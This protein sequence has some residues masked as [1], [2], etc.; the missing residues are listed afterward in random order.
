MWGVKLRWPGLRS[1]FVFN[2]A[3]ITHLNR[4]PFTVRVLST[5][6]WKGPLGTTDKDYSLEPF[7]VRAPPVLSTCDWNGPLGTMDKDYSLEQTTFHC[8][9]TPSSVNV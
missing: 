4:R 3:R 1:E 5:C 6:D 8:A 9:N 7:T 2:R